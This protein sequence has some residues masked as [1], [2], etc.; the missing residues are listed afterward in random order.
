MKRNPG[1]EKQSEDSTVS[2]VKDHRFFSSGKKVPHPSNLPTQESVE[3]N[4]GESMVL[5]SV[6][7]FFSEGFN[8]LFGPSEE[9]R[10]IRR[11][12]AS[13]RRELEQNETERIEDESKNLIIQAQQASL[14]EHLNK[15]SQ[16]Q[17]DLEHRLEQLALN[18]PSMS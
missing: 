10:K 16:Q 14:H 15:L 6:T 8:Y 5:S 9:T 18:T 4:E 13:L 12:T 3:K 17:A 11:E 7:T 2:H 1:D